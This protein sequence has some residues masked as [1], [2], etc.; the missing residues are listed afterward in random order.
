MSDNSDVFDA[1]G[2]GAG[3]RIARFDSKI[4]SAA[5]RISRRVQDSMPIAQSP[6]EDEIYDMI[7]SEFGL[8]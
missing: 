2:A 3:S 6:T 7:I 8:P 1:Q 5:K 4:R